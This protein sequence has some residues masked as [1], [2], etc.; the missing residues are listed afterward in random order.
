MKIHHKSGDP[1]IKN[2]ERLS[3]FPASSLSGHKA[4]LVVPPLV[5]LAARDQRNV[6]EEY[7]G[8]FHQ[9]QNSD[10]FKGVLLRNRKTLPFPRSEGWRGTTH[11][12]KAS[13]NTFG[14]VV[15]TKYL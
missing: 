9:F 6:L 15:I 11:M 13:R 12:V 1:R 4:L 5:S 10:F 14:N 8:K 2:K 7:F 3:L